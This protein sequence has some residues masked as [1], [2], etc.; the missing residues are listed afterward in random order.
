MIHAAT[1]SEG[2][3]VSKVAGWGTYSGVHIVSV[4]RLR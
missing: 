2:V 1:P 3:I 4:R